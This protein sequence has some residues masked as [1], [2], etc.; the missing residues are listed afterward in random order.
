VERRAA[1]EGRGARGV[2]PERGAP[3]ALSER[4]RSATREG[5]APRTT[6]PKWGGKLEPH[7]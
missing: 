3:T 5:R 7:R 1:G 4:E 6:Q 2:P